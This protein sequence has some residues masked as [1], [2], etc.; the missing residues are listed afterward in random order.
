MT[1]IAPT[2]PVPKEW[3]HYIKKQS[4]KFAVGMFDADDAAQVGLETF[5][6]ARKRYDPAKG[7]FEHYAKAAIYN[8]LLKARMAEQRFWAGGDEKPDEPCGAA[9]VAPEVWEAEDAQIDAIEHDKAVTAI[10]DWRVRLPSKPAALVEALYFGDLSQ[11]EYALLEGVSQ[12]RISQRNGDLLARARQ[13]LGYLR[14]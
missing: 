6:K 9:Q 2:P 12:P 5:L 10:A 4:R 14:A 8:A 11:R 3:H 1:R 13:A 7:P